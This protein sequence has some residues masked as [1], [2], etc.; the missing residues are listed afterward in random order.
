MKTISLVLS[1][2]L[3]LYGV[4]TVYVLT[5]LNLSP[6]TYPEI[7]LTTS[8]EVFLVFIFFISMLL[9]GLL[10]SVYSSEDSKHCII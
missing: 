3:L 1:I 8:L 10:Y 5:T 6:E 4:L 9:S 2:L 7:R